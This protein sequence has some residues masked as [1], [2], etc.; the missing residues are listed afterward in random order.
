MRHV[1]AEDLTDP[2]R[3]ARLFE[4]ACAAGCVAR[5][6]SDRLNFF[7]MA[8]HARAAATRNAA[9]L[10]AANVRQRRWHMIRLGDEDAARS[11]LR[12]LGLL[13][14]GARVVRRQ[15]TLVR[16]IVADMLRAL[17]AAS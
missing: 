3:L 4:Q 5:T 9:G 15:P 8:E 17:G 6:E 2:A 13:R 12:D 1:V 11:R 10:F 14:S 16:G 7:A